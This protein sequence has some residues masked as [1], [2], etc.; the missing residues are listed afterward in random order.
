MTKFSTISLVIAIILIISNTL[1][2]LFK[3]EISS[4]SFT[5][6]ILL[7]VVLLINAIIL[8][9]KGKA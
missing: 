5:L 3:A 8:R 7:T 6:S 4:V 9:R 2:F 1:A